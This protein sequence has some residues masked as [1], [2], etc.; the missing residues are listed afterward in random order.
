M[1]DEIPCLKGAMGHRRYLLSKREGK[2]DPSEIDWKRAQQEW[3]AEKGDAFAEGYKAAY[4][5]YV[6]KDR[7]GCD[8]RELDINKWRKY[9]DER[10]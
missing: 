9:A 5:N 10:K 4:C 8:V 7:E 1:E 6:C 3:F 2:K